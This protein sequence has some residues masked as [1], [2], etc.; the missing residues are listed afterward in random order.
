[1]FF[2]TAVGNFTEPIYENVPLPWNSKEVRGRASSVQSAP[3]IK[4]SSSKVPSQV[5][6]VKEDVDKQ[7]NEAMPLKNN[8]LEISNTSNI[9]SQVTSTSIIHS[10]EQSFGKYKNIN[11]VYRRWAKKPSYVQNL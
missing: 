7:H 2:F 5:Q 3:E 10:A 6:L 8:I 11:T 4:S 9:L 1:M